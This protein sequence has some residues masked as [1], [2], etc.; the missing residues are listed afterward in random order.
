[1]K[2][3]QVLIACAVLAAIAGAYALGQR[4]APGPLAGEFAITADAGAT[5]S[6]SRAA[7]A[8]TA[9]AAAPGGSLPLPGA[10]LKDNFA[11]LQARAN[12][13]DAAAAA[14][15]VHDLDRCRRLNASQWK[16]A[17]DAN[18]LT[19]RSTEGMTPA[20]LQTYQLLLDA[21]AL[22]QRRAGEGQAL[23]ADVGDA[24]LGSLVAN[25]A[26]AARL[27]DADARACYLDRG[28]LYDA[29]S[30]LA[31]PESLRAYR[32]QAS[33]LVNAGLA[34]GDW[35]TVDL[36]QRAYQPGAQG[37]LAGLVGAD[38]LQ[39]YR[40]LKLYRLGAEA[41]RSGKL[42]RQLA[43][44]AN[45]LTPVQIAQAD[46]W[47]ETALRDRFEGRSTHATPEGWDACAF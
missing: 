17:S 9:E 28:P 11:R 4:N 25:I 18:E 41:H 40:Y 8:L 24:M 32:S 29:R 6:E 26:Q 35:R 20:Q 43:V 44:A 7:T 3:N 30:L 39:H 12:A 27:G 16:D 10:P 22:R 45:G 15:L 1:M 36:L 19:A 34:A 13:G 14:R 46:A 31:H 37:L 2:R 47:A 21:A 23:C 38:P 33:A 5:A 42:D